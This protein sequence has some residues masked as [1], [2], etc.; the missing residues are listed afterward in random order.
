MKRISILLTCILLLA[1]CNSCEKKEYNMYSTLYG[2]VNDH[3]TG[4]LI[5]GATVVLS[6]GGKTSTTGSDGRY[7]FIDLEPQQYTVTVQKSGYTT[8]RK[9]VVA[10]S[11]ENTEANIPL[12]KIN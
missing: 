11:G 5:G 9:T 10:V 4:E 12:T 7:E 8:N 2:I 1:L 3:E 6:P